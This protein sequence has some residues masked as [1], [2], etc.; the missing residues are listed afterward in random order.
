MPA[1]LMAGAPIRDSRRAA[2]GPVTINRTKGRKARLVARG[3]CPRIC[4]Q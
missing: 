1:A 2:R 4:C 3:E